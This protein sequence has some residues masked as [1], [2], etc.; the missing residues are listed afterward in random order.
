[1]EKDEVGN[2]CCLTRDMLNFFLQKYLLSSP[3]CFIWLLLLILISCQGDK[4]GKI[5]EKKNLSSIHR[6]VESETLLICI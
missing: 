3:L 6:G 1:M 2:F 5:F 4:K